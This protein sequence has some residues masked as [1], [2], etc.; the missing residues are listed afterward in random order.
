MHNG[1]LHDLVKSSLDAYSAKL[2]P[3]RSPK[4]HRCSP[5]NLDFR[6]N[7]KDVGHDGIALVV[8]KWLDLGSGLELEEPVI[9]GGSRGSDLRAILP[10]CYIKPGSLDQAVDVRSAFEEGGKLSAEA[11]CLR[12]GS[13]IAEEQHKQ[14]LDKWAQGVWILQAGHRVQQ[15]SRRRILPPWAFLIFLGFICFAGAL[16]FLVRV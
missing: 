6:L 8:T 3:A 13:L 1:Q 7:F 16:Q 15:Y 5:C 9:P 10:D 11:L 4:I 14:L 2:K 12:N